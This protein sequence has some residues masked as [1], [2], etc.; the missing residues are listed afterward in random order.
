MANAI[1]LV[2]EKGI[3]NGIDYSQIKTMVKTELS[4]VD[5]HRT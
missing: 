1:R 3:Q 5:K 2:D 4:G